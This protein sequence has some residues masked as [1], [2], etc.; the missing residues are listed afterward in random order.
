MKQLPKELYSLISKA[1]GNPL[2]CEELAFGLLESKAITIADGQ[3][4]LSDGFEN[5]ESIACRN[6]TIESLI[7]T[8]IDT[9][10]VHAQTVLK[11]GMTKK[12]K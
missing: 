8:R 10:P 9:L 12:I 11:I 6:Y 1:D 2:F 5:K 4:V 7:N 3:C